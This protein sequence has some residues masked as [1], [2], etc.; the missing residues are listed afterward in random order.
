MNIDASRGFLGPF[1]R[2]YLT[3]ITA[4]KEKD[5]HIGFNIKIETRKSKFLPSKY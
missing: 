2:V 3:R 5:H 1:S 4:F